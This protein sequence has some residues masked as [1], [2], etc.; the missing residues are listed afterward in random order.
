MKGSVL[1]AQIVNEYKRKQY[2]SEKRRQKC[3]EKQCKKCQ[4]RNM[5]TGSEEENECQEEDLVK[6]QKRKNCKIK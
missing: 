5:Y 1:A 4:Y 2:Y 3:K 6:Y